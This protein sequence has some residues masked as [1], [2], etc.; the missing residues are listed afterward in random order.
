MHSNNDTD[1]ILEAYQKIEE[2]LWNRVK[3]R[4]SQAV[5]ATGG[6][7]NQAKGGIQKSIGKQVA[8]VGNKTASLYGGDPKKST[9]TKKG[10]SLIKKGRGNI[11]SGKVAGDHAKYRSYVKNAVDDVVADL[12]KLGMSV[13][14][15][16][17]LH[18]DLTATITN[19]LS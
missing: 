16:A 2:G 15:P 19:N 9:I 11:A 6:L 3:A 8:K 14:D 1:L 4:G 10:N 17:K 13:T 18:Q 5:A 12:K 7:F